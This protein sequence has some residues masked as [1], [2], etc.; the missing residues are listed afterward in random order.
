MNDSGH[1]LGPLPARAWRKAEEHFGT[2]PVPPAQQ[3]RRGRRFIQVYLAVL[4]AAIAVFAVLALYAHNGNALL[5]IDV[6]MTR[7]IQGVN[8]PLY[9]WVLTHTSDLGFTPGDVISYVVVFA[10]LAAS[11][12]PAEAL[13][14]VVS[15]LLASLVGSE[16]K[17]LIGRLRPAGHGVHVAGHVT[18]YSFP[19][20]HVT[21]YVILFG[22]AF[23]LVFVTWRR[24]WLRSGILA[25]LALLVVLVGPSRVYLGQHWPSDVLG[26]YLFAGVWLAGSI[27]L[28]LFLLRRSSW[29]QRYAGWGRAWNKRTHSALGT[30]VER[31]E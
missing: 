14:T 9:G 3:E 13:L 29:W 27:E 26:A 5:A 28:D 10:G 15:A 11:G 21:Q 2:E 12:L 6:P 23:F 20:G 25:V 17:I 19:S 8:L 4:L 16:I 18:G 30:I 1:E 31:K 24:G 7:A 22:F